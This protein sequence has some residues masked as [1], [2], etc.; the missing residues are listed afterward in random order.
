MDIGSIFLIFAVTL[1]VALFIGKPLFEQRATSVT[2]EEKALSTLMAERDRVLDALQ[3]MDFDYQLRKIPT[4]EYPTQRAALVQQGAMILKKLDVL[5]MNHKARVG[6]DHGLPDMIAAHEAE[7]VDSAGDSESWFRVGEPD[8]EI[9][10]LIAARRRTR[11]EKSAGFCPQC[12]HVVL[13]S[14]QFC[15]KCGT[16]LVQ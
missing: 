2:E 8:D 9:E 5:Q 16:T 1:I 11:E 7:S 15:S 14:D 6:T 3:E 4:S 13:K 10:A 12:G